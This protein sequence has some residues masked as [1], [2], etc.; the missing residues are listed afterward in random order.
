MPKPETLA[1]KIKR[2]DALV[3]CKHELFLQ[4]IGGETIDTVYPCAKELAVLLGAIFGKEVE[5][6]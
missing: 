3:L 5:F 2:A 4:L 1:D 6:G